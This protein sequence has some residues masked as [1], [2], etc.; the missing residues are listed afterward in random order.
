MESHITFQR[1]FLNHWLWQ[2][3]PYA[4]GQAWIY[5][6]LKA[7]PLDTLLVQNNQRIALKKGQLCTSESQ[8]MKEFG[9]GNTK[10]RSF[11]QFLREDQRI[12]SEQHAKGTIITICDY[13]KYQEVMG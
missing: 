12:T 7:E 3:K 2:D 11:L 9:W 10:V 5:L 1:D 13:E 8:L 4:K 6:L